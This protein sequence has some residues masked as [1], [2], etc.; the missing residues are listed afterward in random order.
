MIFSEQIWRTKIQ[1]AIQILLILA[2]TLFSQLYKMGEQPYRLWDEAR[3]AQNAYEMA[4]ADNIFV[5]QINGEPDNWNSKPPLMIW[6]QA[7][8]IK[9][10]GFNEISTRLPSVLSAILCTLIAAAFVFS[11]TNS[12]WSAVLAAVVLS[13]SIGY[14]SYHGTRYGEFDSMLALFTTSYLLAYFMYI[15]SEGPKANRYL[16]AFFVLLSGAVLTKSVAGLLFTPAL[17]VYTLVRAKLK[18][19]LCNRNLYIGVAFFL[20]LVGAYYLL[21]EHFSP[22]Y[23]QAVAENELGGRYLEVNEEHKGG[24]DFYWGYIK[25][26]GWGVW[27]WALPVSLLV[28]VI[29]SNGRFKRALAFALLT[30]SLFLIVISSSATKLMW[31]S[32]PMYP[33]L[34][35]IVGLTVYGFARIISAI[36]NTGAQTVVVA[37]ATIFSIQPMK[38]LYLH[39][40]YT[41]DDLN[42]DNHYALSYYLRDALN[43]KR[44]LDGATFLFNGYYPEHLLYI[45]AMKDKGKDIK[46]VY[47]TG[48]IS[49]NAGDKVI[50]KDDAN[51]Q[52]IQQNYKV[53]MKEEFYGVKL[54]VINNAN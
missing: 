31:Y 41:G 44:N 42:A 3:L 50:V 4:H 32:L 27:Y 39:L 49:F 14:I 6:A 1:P 37:L 43:D 13:S 33:L 21:R 5:T 54:F 48:N 36:S 34:A 8:C 53:S 26:A 7:L 11:I 52:Y 46:A 9:A 18:D 24:W 17:F 35:I 22:G 38:E 16:L 30:A 19:T 25:S 51:M 20:L 28:F 29:S 45:T 23:L 47:N 10:N 15:E 2:I 12:G 40:K